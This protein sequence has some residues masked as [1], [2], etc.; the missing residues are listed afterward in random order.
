MRK[1]KD[2]ASAIAIAT[3]IDTPGG[4]RRTGAFPGRTCKS[5]VGINVELV[6]LVGA[7]FCKREQEPKSPRKTLG[8][9]VASP[10]EDDVGVTERR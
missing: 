8:P 5:Y 6:Q 7:V 2:S 1:N 10:D 4:D 9:S 3:E